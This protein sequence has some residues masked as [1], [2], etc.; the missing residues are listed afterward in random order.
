MQVEE[1]PMVDSSEMQRTRDG[2]HQAALK[3]SFAAI[4]RSRRVLA[5]TAHLVGKPPKRLP[6]DRTAK[7]VANEVPPSS[8]R[9]A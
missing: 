1:R 3:T 9:A 5:E 2:Y 8:S 7:P 4:A 6:A